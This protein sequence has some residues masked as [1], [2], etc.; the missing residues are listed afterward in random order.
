MRAWNKGVRRDPDKFPTLKRDDQWADYE[1][2]L[3]IVAS[4]QD[5]EEVLD[6]GHNP[7]TA[8]KPLFDK[9]NTFMSSV[10]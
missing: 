3:R 8:D 9:K 4:V 1:P 6:P 10:F 2:D 7:S 5:V